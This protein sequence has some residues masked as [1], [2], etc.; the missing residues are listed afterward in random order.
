MVVQFAKWGNSLALR[1]PN[2][3]AKEIDARPGVAA[4]VNVEDGRLVVR[5]LEHAPDYDL[6]DLLAGMTTDH[7]HPETSTGGAVGNEF[8]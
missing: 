1:I 6:D 7:A 5:L 3:M 4:D 8:A 2:A